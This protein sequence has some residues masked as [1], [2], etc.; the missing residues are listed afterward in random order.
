MSI[1][2]PLSASPYERERDYEIALALVISLHQR[3]LLSESE[4][5]RIDA[6][7]AEK[8]SAVVGQIRCKDT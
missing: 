5:A 7:L 4:L 6:I 2:T 1:E 8:F 3:G